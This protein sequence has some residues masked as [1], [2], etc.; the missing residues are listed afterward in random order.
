MKHKNIGIDWI[1]PPEKTCNDPKCPW[2]GK[3]KIRGQLIEGIVVSA[4]PQRTVIVRRDYLH[5]V[6]KYERYERRRSKIA[7]HNPE[8]VNAKEGDRV[9]IGET[10]PLSKTKHF[11]VLQVLER[12][13]E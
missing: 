10:R 5:Y 7:A 13:K 3:V 12:R 8:C 6:H 2:H 4:K 11:V 9:I 1:K